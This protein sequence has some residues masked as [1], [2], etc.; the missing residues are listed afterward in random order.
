MKPLSNKI[1]IPLLISD[2]VMMSITTILRPSLGSRGYI[3]S[4]V[5]LVL[6]FISGIVAVKVRINWERNREYQM[7]VRGRAP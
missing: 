3:S 1:V 5:I 4:M 7:R 6:T 2:I